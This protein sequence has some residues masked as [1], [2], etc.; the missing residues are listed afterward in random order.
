MRVY[1]QSKAANLL[2][3]Q[4]LARRLAGSGVTVNAMHP[5]GVATR[6]GQQ[7]GAFARVLTRALSVFFR[8]PAQGADTAVWLATA[9][10]LEGVSG[11][12]SRSAASER[13]GGLGGGRGDRSAFEESI[14]LTGRERYGGG[15]ATSGLSSSRASSRRW[16]RCAEHCRARARSRRADARAGDRP[17]R[18]RAPRHAPRRARAPARRA[19]ARRAAS[20]L[21]ARGGDASGAYTARAPAYAFGARFAGARSSSR[22]PRSERHRAVEAPSAASRA[23]SAASPVVTLR[24]SSDADLVELHELKTLGSA[25]ASRTG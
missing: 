9:P 15:D 22:S 16:S 13:A 14:R 8:T 20:R 1:G 23:T 18:A 12:Y 6:L 17:P 4:E 2:F 25:A 21:G 19:S 11:R 7:N 24:S 10:E 3:T 5:G